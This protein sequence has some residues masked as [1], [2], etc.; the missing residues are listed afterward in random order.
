[1][2][3]LECFPRSP[4]PSPSLPS[5]LPPLPSSAK[6]RSFFFINHCLKFFYPIWVK[7][8]EMSF[9]VCVCVCVCVCELSLTYSTSWKNE[10]FFFFFFFRFR[11][12]V[13]SCFFFLGIWHVPWLCFCDWIPR[14][15]LWKL[16][17]WTPHACDWLP[18]NCGRPSPISSA[19]S[20]QLCLLAGNT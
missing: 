12:C 14:R 2:F 8:I 7:I 11:V 3:L 17:T 15:G 6:D 19:L 20:C 5:S 16:S 13:C 10:I 4:L 9:C 1:M 18:W